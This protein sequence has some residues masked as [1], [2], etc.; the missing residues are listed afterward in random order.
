MDYY[1][2]LKHQDTGHFLAVKKGFSW[3]AL[4]CPYGWFGSKGM[5]K[6]AWIH[7]ACFILLSWTGIVP[8]IQIIYAGLNA[9]RQY[10]EELNMKGYNPVTE[11]PARDE[12]HAIEELYSK[13]RQKRSRRTA[14][15][16]SEAKDELMVS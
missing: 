11:I 12:Q 5:S 15:A 14:E 6:M 9:N 13:L 1:T 8:I 10:V 7:A 2:I 16:S 4:L 3:T